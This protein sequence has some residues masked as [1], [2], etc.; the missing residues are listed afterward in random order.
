MSRQIPLRSI[1]PV[2][3]CVLTLSACGG[4][5]VPPPAPVDA[6]Q[7]QAV[8]ADPP[9]QNIQCGTVP[10]NDGQQAKVIIRQG[11]VECAEAVTLLTQYF[12]RVTPAAAASPDGAGP[13]ALD[14]WT[15]GSD[16]GSVL[17]ATC[18]TEDGRQVG[19]EPAR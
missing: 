6:G 15:C 10:A 1:G 7:A 12:A 13:V 17:T 16:P 11:A 18:S 19:S 2:A 14:P 3:A 5:G 9:A 4:Q 8:L